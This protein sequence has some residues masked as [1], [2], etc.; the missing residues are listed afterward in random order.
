[1]NHGKHGPNNPTTNRGFLPSTVGFA[2]KK[3]SRSLDEA[4]ICWVNPSPTSHHPRSHWLVGAVQKLVDYCLKIWIRILKSAL[5]SGASVWPLYWPPLMIS[6]SKLLIVIFFDQTHIEYRQPLVFFWI[7]CF[8]VG[9]VTN[10]S[11]SFF[12]P[13]RGDRSWWKRSCFEG[14][15]RKMREFERESEEISHD[16]SWKWTTNFAAHVKDDRVFRWVST[17][18]LKKKTSPQKMGGRFE[19]P[20]LMDT[21]STNPTNQP[22]PTHRGYDGLVV[23]LEA[24]HPWRSLLRSLSGYFLVTERHKTPWKSFLWDMHVFYVDLTLYQ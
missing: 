13:P 5:V 8:D 9:C 17:Q 4:F 19:P 1:M 3:P 10:V 15:P 7:F 23:H 21:G 2:E 12:S 22:F 20:N 16:E 14:L 6:G 11:L 18:P 24:S